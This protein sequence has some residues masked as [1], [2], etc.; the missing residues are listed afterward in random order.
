MLPEGLRKKDKG[1]ILRENFGFC[2]EYLRE[3]LPKQLLAGKKPK[4][5]TET[6]R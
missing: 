5:Q 4:E 3:M 6:Q 1:G 2:P